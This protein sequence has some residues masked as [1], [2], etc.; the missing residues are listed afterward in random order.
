MEARNTALGKILART[1]RAKI[2]FSDRLKEL[3]KQMQDE[4]QNLL[5]DNQ[6]AL[7]DI[8][9]S[10]QKRLS[11]WSHPGVTLRLEWQQDPQKSIRI[12]EPW[13]QIITGEGKFEGELSRFGHG[14]QRSYLLALLQEL[15][16]SDDLQGPRLLLACE[17]PELYQHPPQARHLFNVLQKLGQ[18]NSQVIISTHSPYFVS[19]EKF[20][21]M[22]IVRKENYCSRIFSVTFKK[23]AE[24]I[25]QATGERYSKP[26]GVQAKIHQALQP[27]LSE[28]FFTPRLILVEGLEDLAYITTYLNLMGLWDEFR[29]YGCHIVPTYGKS[30]MIR[31][32]AIANSLKISTFVIFDSDGHETNSGKRRWHEKDNKAILKLCGIENPEPFPSD[33]LWNNRVVMWQS[34]IGLVVENDIG[35]E[36][37]NK[38]RNKA[39]QEYG[40]AKNLGKNILDIGASLGSVD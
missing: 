18:A 14:L 29:R 36:E 11:E 8:S 34:E 2:N 39:H 10:L 4:Y 25:S 15:S 31:P 9:N 24:K 40:R 38:Y 23:L 33:N 35:K 30:E 27:Q 20:E 37:W 12:D 6:H 26:S 17:E 5:D 32:L 3:R 28:M 16:G 7:E 21:D 19:G 1:V 13:A 22:R